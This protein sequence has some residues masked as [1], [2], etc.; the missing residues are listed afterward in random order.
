VHRSASRGH[1]RLIFELAPFPAAS[2]LP[3]QRWMQKPKDRAKK[4][5]SDAVVW[6]AYPKRSSKKYKSGI[7]RDNGWQI[8]GGCDLAARERNC[9]CMGFASGVWN[10]SSRRGCGVGFGGSDAVLPL[11]GLAGDFQATPDLM[12]QSNRQHS[13]NCAAANEVRF[14]E[15]IG[16]GRRDAFSN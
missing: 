2:R 3:T 7:N 12:L 5:K 9:E 14:V 11:K 15:K 4:A 6:F 1:R 10:T 13:V 16:S 8:L